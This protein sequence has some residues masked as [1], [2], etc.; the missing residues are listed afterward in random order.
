MFVTGISSKEECSII[1]I[2]EDQLFLKLDFITKRLGFLRDPLVTG[3]SRG[4]M[5]SC[6]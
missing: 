4:P 5:S 3:K 2:S 6:L 1:G